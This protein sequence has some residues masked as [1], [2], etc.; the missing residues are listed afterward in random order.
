MEWPP[1]LHVMPPGVPRQGLKTLLPGWF[2]H[3]ASSWSKV[4]SHGS[5]LLSQWAS[6]WSTWDSSKVQLGFRRDYSTIWEVR[7]ATFLRPELRNCHSIISDI[8]YL[9]KHSWIPPLFKEKE[10]QLC[11][12]VKKCQRNLA[13]FN[14]AQ[15]LASLH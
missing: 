11:L 14:L 15:I 5:Q 13:K 1:F 12:W 2:I 8:Y 9:S 3:M 10:H 7:I 4:Y 6:P